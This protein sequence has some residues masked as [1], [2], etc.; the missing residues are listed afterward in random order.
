MAQR[1]RSLKMANDVFRRHAGEG[2][3][4]HKG[5]GLFYFAADIEHENVPLPASI[6][7]DKLEQVSFQDVMDAALEWKKALAGMIIRN[8]PMSGRLPDRTPFEIH[9]TRTGRHIPT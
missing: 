5:K 7:A 6:M 9:G 8:I 1:Y 4:L 3:R 2:C